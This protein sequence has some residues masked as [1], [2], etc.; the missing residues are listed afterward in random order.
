MVPQVQKVEKKATDSTCPLCH[1]GGFSNWQA[2]RNSKVYS[3]GVCSISVTN[4]Y[5]GPQAERKV[6]NPP[7]AHAK[8]GQVVLEIS[9]LRLRGYQMLLW[10]R[11]M[12]AVMGKYYPGPTI[13]MILVIAATLS[14]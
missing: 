13:I 11:R 8:S 14:T 3:I 7:P 12:V 10:F 6:E 1:T 4:L 2:L 5:E 9:P